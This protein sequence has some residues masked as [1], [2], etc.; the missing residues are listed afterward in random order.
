MAFPKAIS[1]L[2]TN[3]YK[4]EGNSNCKGCGRPIQWWLTPRERKMPLE[5]D[6]DGNVEPHFATCPN[7]QEFRK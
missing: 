4:F 7:V 1:E 3:G 5:V 2:V 6:L